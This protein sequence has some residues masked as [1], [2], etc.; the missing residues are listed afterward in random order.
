MAHINSDTRWVNVVALVIDRRI[1]PGNKTWE[2]K[3][4][5]VK[6]ERERDTEYFTCAR[7]GDLSCRIR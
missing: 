4:K 1:Y 7:S 6:R 2:G 5:N 3:K